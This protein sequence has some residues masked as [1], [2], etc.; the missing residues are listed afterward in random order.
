MTG[1]RGGGGRGLKRIKRVR[2]KTE[3]GVQ[4]GDEVARP[5]ARVILAFY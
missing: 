1:G 2:N 5:V 4:L 3:I